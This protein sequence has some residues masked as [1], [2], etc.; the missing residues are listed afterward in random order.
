V[1]I[2][3]PLLLTLQLGIFSLCVQ[4]KFTEIRRP[5][6]KFAQFSLQICANEKGANLDVDRGSANLPGELGPEA[7]SHNTTLP[8]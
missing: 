2:L 7:N 8:Y 4:G 5:C 3:Q 6:C 1:A